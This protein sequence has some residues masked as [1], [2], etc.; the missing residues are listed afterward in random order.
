MKF[1]KKIYNHALE[2][3]LHPSIYKRIRK[4]KALIHKDADPNEFRS[5]GGLDLDTYRYLQ[6]SWERKKNEIQG[7]KEQLIYKYGSISDTPLKVGPCK[8]IDPVIGTKRPLVLL[9]DFKDRNHTA[10]YDSDYFKN[11]LFSKGSNDSLRDYFLEAS[12]NQLD[13]NGDVSDEW[14]F[15]FAPILR[16]PG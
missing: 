1:V 15:I 10:I 13:I 9:I 16:V 3:H 12:W 6:K 4:T 8:K 14:Y 2:R 7:D 11:L 5:K